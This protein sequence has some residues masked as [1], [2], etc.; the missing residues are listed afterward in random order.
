MPLPFTS[1]TDSKKYS[2][3]NKNRYKKVLPKS[4][5]RFN[6]KKQYFFHTNNL[7]KKI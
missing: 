3:N 2:K 7:D 6:E 5:F 1:P 4:L